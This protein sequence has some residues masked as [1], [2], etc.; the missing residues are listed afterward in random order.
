MNSSIYVPQWIKDLRNNYIT[1][2]FHQ[3]LIDGNIKDIEF[4]CFINS[5][6]SLNKTQEML[7]ISNQHLM[8][9]LLNHLGIDQIIYYSSSCGLNVYPHLNNIGTLGVKQQ[10]SEI[11]SSIML[12]DIS[13][14]PQEPRIINDIYQLNK[15][16]TTEWRV[17]DKDISLKI[18][19]VID[20]AENIVPELPSYDDSRNI[21]YELISSWGK[22]D[23]IARLGHISILLSDNRQLVR[24]GANSKEDGTY[25]INIPI[26]NSESRQRYF[27]FIKT[28]AI[29]DS[30]LHDYLNSKEEA[31]FELSQ[32]TRGFR[33]IDCDN[34]KKISI[35]KD[36]GSQ[37]FF[38]GKETASHLRIHKL[39]MDQ[40]DKVLREAG[41][42]M[43]EPVET[44]LDF[45]SIGGLQHAKEYFI[46]IAQAIRSENEK[47][48]K[49]IPKGVL[50]VGP[51]GTG[52]TV[53]AK[54]LARQSGLTLVRMGNIRSMWVG[55]SERNLTHVLSLLKAMAPVIVFVDEIDQALGARQSSSGDSG[56]S[57]RIFQQILEFM[58]D[59]DNRGDVIWIAATNRADILDDAMVSRFDRIIPVLLPG[60]ID[61]W[62][63]VFYGILRQLKLDKNKLED[64]IVNKFLSNKN[65]F[66]YLNQHSGRSI[67]TVIRIAYQNQLLTTK[68]DSEKLTLNV[69]EETF[70]AFKIN[71]NS[72]MYELQT[73]LALAAC[74]DINFIQSPSKDYSYA[75]K[76]L[77]EM[78]IGI[79]ETRNNAGID[80]HIKRLRLE[81]RC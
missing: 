24:R 6:S 39:L 30:P 78:V 15:A 72:H 27:K 19:V 11:K 41:R 70:K 4:D 76:D 79:K 38:F 5:K 46:N 74:N 60:S 77:N 34:I 23:I 58:G 65:N 25:T 81:L 35:E 13:L 26:P 64:D 9:K 14:D 51:P 17:E 73:L 29:S 1:G 42:N 2:S 8:I 22:S 18:A 31:V 62:R 47:Y 44:E 59:N 50:M 54:A 52:K 67:E 71:I 10:I 20:N 68:G 36:K 28:Q 21:C 12:K 56:V 57:G 61:E 3:F 75:N 53:L 45:D 37:S 49:I 69:L 7:L 55:E 63:S 48:R 32:L 33:L 43:L 16:L 40:K 66:K 80:E